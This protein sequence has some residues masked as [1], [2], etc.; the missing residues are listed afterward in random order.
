MKN[1]IT[2]LFIT[3]ISAVL[4]FLTA[5]QDLNGVTT[6]GYIFLGIAAIFVCYC[7]G[8][9]VYAMFSKSN[10]DYERVDEILY[11]LDND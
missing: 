1:F 5:N 4:W 9:F 2:F 3:V 7:I 6:I 10:I 11:P 8:C